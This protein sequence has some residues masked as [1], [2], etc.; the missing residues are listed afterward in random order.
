MC[1]ECA[2]AC[3]CMSM[4]V[5]MGVFMCAVHIHFCTCVWRA[6]DSMGV[7]LRN[8]I[9]LLWD[10]VSHWSGPQ[11][12]GLHWLARESRTLPVSAAHLDHKC[13]HLA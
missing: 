10:G 8:T 2:C 6:G 4:C 12:S 7:L 13:G 3:M 9:Y 11:P 5:H 1:C